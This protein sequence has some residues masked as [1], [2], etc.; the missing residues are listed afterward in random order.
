MIVFFATNNN[1]TSCTVFLTAKLDNHIAIAIQVVEHWSLVLRTG[2]RN[3]RIA[4]STRKLKRDVPVTLHLHKR[5]TL[6]TCEHLHDADLLGIWFC[7]HLA[8]CIQPQMVRER[9]SEACPR[10]DASM[11]V[12][13]FVQAPTCVKAT[14]FLRSPSPLASVCT[15]CSFL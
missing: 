11:L 12:T 6:C 5:I 10:C 13:V 3:L 1:I 9:G 7:R 15:L 2:D 4:V 14:L 8:T